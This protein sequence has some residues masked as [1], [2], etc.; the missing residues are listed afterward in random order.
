[1]RFPRYFS[2]PI[3][4]LL[5]LLAA[6]ADEIDYRAKAAALTTAR[7]HPSLFVRAT[8]AH[9]LR[10]VDDLRAGIRSGH[11]KFLW[12]RLKT[13]VDAQLDEPPIAPME[14]KGGE[15]VLRN[16]SYSFI[17]KVANRI[18]DTALVALVEEDPKYVDAVREQIMVLFDEEKWPEWSDQAHLNVGLNA[19]L[20]HGQLVV[21]IA[22]AYDWLYHQLTPDQRRAIIE[23]LDRCAIEPYKKGVEAKEH[24]S[25]R[26][27]NWM[28]V[29][30]GG[31][32]IAGM[33]LGP[34]HP[35][36]ALLVE[37][38]LG[39]MENY[40]E[41]LG[42]EGE[43]NESVQYAGSMAYVVRYFMAMRYASNGADKPFDRHDFDKF[44]E[45][46]M[47][48]TFPPG[49]V[50]G[51]GDPAPAMPPVVVPVAAVAAAKQNPVFQW[52]YE[53]YNDK[54]LES[55]RKRALELL[56]YDASL[57]AESP[58]GH[59][60]L[61]RAYHYQGH[62]VSSRSSWDPDSC[63]SVVYGKSGRESY[64]GHADWGQVC[65]DGYGER[66]VIDL[67]SPPGYP[68]NH[69]ERYYNYQQFGHNVFMIGQNE[70]GGVSVRAKGPHGETTWSEFD[71]DRG[72]AW[73][74]DLSGVYGE[75][76]D[77]SRTVVHLLPR[78][79]V[80]LDEAR[81]P[82]V[83]PISMRWHLAREVEP[84]DDGTFFMKGKSAGLSGRTM[85]LD[86]GATLSTGTHAYVAPYNK[87]RLGAEFKQRN[88]SYIELKTS[89]RVCRILTLFAIYEAGGVQRLWKENDDG[90][91]IETP[92]G[93]VQV[94]VVGGSLKVQR[95]DGAVWQAPLD[96]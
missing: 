92:E 47:M 51:F 89:D 43:F 39:Q 6:S 26:R 62:L 76:Y 9:G 35:D 82:E 12:E 20:R 74:F 65:V 84:N 29:V 17:A 19:D 41:I 4:L 48:F 11:G 78:I 66:L 94:A 21:P 79:A 93:L 91:E 63:T 3:V 77:V 1:M 45:W 5:P 36:S 30:L 24:W 80:V 13:A 18:L 49:R 7:E 14:E 95:E 96:R 67:G 75:G 23:G 53:Q 42:P 64:H 28:T 55:H 61:G 54:M 2:A 57:Q 68:K 27:S 69:K 56:Y 33:A 85:R 71:P 31:F 38:S 90:W 22:L 46:Y 25:R 15:Q 34:D 83:E 59:L 72:A 88:E 32:G 73:T 81:L 44:Y 58:S 70:T 87:H 60:P 37:N 50:A 8:P 16:R 52:F 86:G 40:L 10:T